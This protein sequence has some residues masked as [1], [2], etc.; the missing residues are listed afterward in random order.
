M[1]Q[2]KINYNS[3]FMS[4]N[5]LTQRIRSRL[6]IILA[7]TLMAIQLMIPF[8]PGL[9]AQVTE[10]S[11][12]IKSKTQLSEQ[13][14]RAVEGYFQ[15]STNQD[16]IILFK[17]YRDTLL[18]TLVWNNRVIHF[19]PESSLT[20]RSIEAV[21][22]GPVLT[23]FIV[24]ATGEVT[25]MKLGNEMVWNRIKNYKPIVRKEMD[26]TPDQLKPFEGLYQFSKDSVRFIQFTVEGNALVLKQHWDGN[27][28]SFV[29]ET[30]LDFFSRDAPM[31]SL[32]FSRN[33]EGQV[34]QA[35]AFKR[36][37]WIK[38]AKPALTDRDLKLY[39]GKYQSTD[40]PDNLVQL[41][42]SHSQLVLKQ[43][44]DG[45]EIDLNPMTNTYF[46]NDAQS[47]PLQVLRGKDGSVNQ[48]IILG[49]DQFNRIK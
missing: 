27:K 16:A 11:G 24:N 29:P 35:V 15:S 37:V 25:G 18:G 49:M 36:D 17:A 39:E 6:S 5:K 47:F 22:R 45:K 30:P 20:F 19:L 3:V 43:L 10:K 7:L 8:S 32:S 48:I 28:I 31:F 12:Q 14:W 4:L 13:E 38:T 34:S 1:D 46:Y 9:H 33:N 21:E 42:A 44:W 41:T 2:V 23:S 40:D 26:H